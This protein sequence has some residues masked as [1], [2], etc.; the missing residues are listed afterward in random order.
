M[1]IAIKENIAADIALREA[2]T[3]P[4]LDRYMHNLRTIWDTPEMYP[5][6]P[7]QNLPEIFDRIYQMYLGGIPRPAITPAE[8]GE[9]SVMWEKGAK[10]VTLLIDNTNMTALKIVGNIDTMEST[11]EDVHLTADKDWDDIEEELQSALGY[12]RR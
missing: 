10:A 6:P 8:Y 2:E 1:S 7:E 11:G 5:L 4:L 12:R 3:N 9:I